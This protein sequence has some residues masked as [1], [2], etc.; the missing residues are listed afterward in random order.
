[1][2]CVLAICE[3][4][5][6]NIINNLTRICLLIEIVNDYDK[7]CMTEDHKLLSNRPAGAIDIG[8]RISFLGHIK[9]FN[10]TDIEL[11]L[12]RL[13]Q[14]FKANAVKEETMAPTLL[15]LISPKPYGVLKNLASPKN[16][17][18]LDFDAEFKE[19]SSLFTQEANDSVRFKFYKRDRLW[20]ETDS[21]FIVGFKHLAAQCNFNTFLKEV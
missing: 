13:H 19:L 14:Y 2:Q 17:D 20:S 5:F 3:F 9:E 4:L 7:V 12:K 18:S 6:N 8:L 1:M 21:N 10:E 15:T 11:Y 16:V